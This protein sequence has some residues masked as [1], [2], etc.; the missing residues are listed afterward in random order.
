MWLKKN[1]NCLP[2]SFAPS[3]LC[4]TYYFFLFSFRKALPAVG[5]RKEIVDH[6]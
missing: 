4:V 1:L 5:R 6:S 3:L 2:E